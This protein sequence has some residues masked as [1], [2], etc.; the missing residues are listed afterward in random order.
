M[1]ATTWIEGT[2]LGDTLLRPATET[3]DREAV[4]FPDARYTYGEVLERSIA[5]GRSLIGLGIRAGDHVGILMPNTPDFVFALF[6]CSL[7]GAVAV[8]LNTRYKRRELAYVVE[9]GDL[10]TVLTSDVIAEHVDFADLLTGALEGLAEAADPWNLDLAVAPRLRR[11]VLFGPTTRPGMVTEAGFYATGA[12]VEGAEVIERSRRV[13]IRDIM[14]MLYTSGTTANPKGCLLTHEAII[15]DWIAVA[16]RNGL[17]PDDGFWS[18]CPM[19]HMS[20]TGPMIS[21][22]IRSA[23]FLT[24]THF[25]ANTALDFIAEEAA[26]HL[27]TA[28]PTIAL[29]ILRHPDYSPERIPSVRW[30]M[31]IAPKDTLRLMQSLIP[32]AVHVSAYGLTEATGTVCLGDI[33]DT[34][35]ERETSGRPLEGVELR[36]VDPETGDDTPPDVPGEVLIRGFNCF[37][38]YYRD[39]EKTA[40]TLDEDRWVHTGDLASIDEHGF[41]TY[42]GRVKDMLKVGGENVAP[43]EIE[44]HLTGH[45]AVVLAQVVGRP[46]EKYTEVPVAFVQL[47]PGQN[48][49]EEELIEYCRGEIASFKIPR[50]VH[51]VDEWPMSAT[52]IRKYRLREIA[53]GG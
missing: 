35:D 27:Y 46:D 36:T 33:G 13:R 26:T 43:A 51:F 28:F 1:T 41:L 2:T 18:P 21:A 25:D 17:G 32:Q 23:R 12:D 9:N 52:K 16:D 47:V 49:T 31:N 37:E 14:A 10:V 6:G 7:V 30:I 39:A 45:P 34:W 53:A 38:G 19:F 4:V 11:V 20:G 22:F 15:R 3:P 50:A 5:V 42:V 29:G 24:M 40:A 44:A 8:P 48:A